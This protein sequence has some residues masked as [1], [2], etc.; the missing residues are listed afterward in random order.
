M[1]DGSV[2]W[3]VGV[4]GGERSWRALGAPKGLWPDGFVVI[5]GVFVHAVGVSAEEGGEWPR[6]GGG[7][8]AD[9]RLDG[10]LEFFARGVW[11]IVLWLTLAWTVFLRR[12]WGEVGGAGILGG[13]EGAR[14][15]RY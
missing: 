11:L 14:G 4:G 6:G 9:A 15:R 3:S 10:R 12:V 5:D 8:G 1:F 2:P 13:S 7:R